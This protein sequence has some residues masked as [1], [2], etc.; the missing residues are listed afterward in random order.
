MTEDLKKLRAILTN[1]IDKIIDICDKRGEEFPSLSEPARPSEF[2]PQGIRNDP[3]ILE[4][5]AFGVSAAAQLLA[6][7]QPPH[8]TLINSV[9]K[10]SLIAYCP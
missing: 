8:V 10:V 6:T 3:G 9:T 2:S 4:A 1:S 5:I 7:L